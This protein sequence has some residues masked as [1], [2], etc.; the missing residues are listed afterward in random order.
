MIAIIMMVL[1]VSAF[2]V[3]MMFS[4]FRTFSPLSFS[5][6]CGFERLPPMDATNDPRLSQIR[7]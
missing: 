5:F 6:L 1:V 3:F 4:G 2:P 7:I